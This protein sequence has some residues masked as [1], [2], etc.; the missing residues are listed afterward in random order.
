MAPP[1]DVR[2]PGS[3]EASTSKKSKRKSNKLAKGAKKLKI[4]AKEEVQKVEGAVASDSTNKD[5]TEAVV[6]KKSVE[7]KEL[8]LS[9]SI[10]GKFRE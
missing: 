7:P 9:L 4:D 2:K 8:P 6:E 10:K 1:K 5:E 3:S